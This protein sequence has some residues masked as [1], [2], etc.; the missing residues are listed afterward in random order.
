MSAW[1]SLH[2]KRFARAMLHKREISRSGADGGQAD[3][4][5]LSV[6]GQG[7]AETANDLVLNVAMLTRFLGEMCAWYKYNIETLFRQS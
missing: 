3:C 4:L 5:H 7:N 2:A 6:A 1:R